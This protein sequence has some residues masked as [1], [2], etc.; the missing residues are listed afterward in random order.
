MK[1]AIGILIT[2]ALFAWMFSLCSPAGKNKTGHEYMPDMY[3]AVGYEANQYN[4]YYW[5]HWDKESTFSKAQLS[6]PRGTV[7]GSVPRGMTAVYYGGA[8]KLDIVRGKNAPNAIAATPNGHAP[9]YFQNTEDDRAR[10]E[11]DMVNNPF[12]ITKAGLDRAKPLYEI[13]C[14]ICHGNDGGGNGAL[15]ATEKYPAQPKNLVA[16]DMIAAGNGRYYFAIMYGK[17]VM[18]SYTDKLSYE[19]R[20][21]VIHYIRALQAKAKKLEYNEKANTLSNVEQP[22]GG[23]ASGPARSGNTVAAPAA[24][25]PAPTN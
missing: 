6:Q 8:E 1:Y 14:G 7:E 11:K 15:V 10:C 3:H 2:V 16:D 9:F 13:Y 25:A 21:Q 18:G 22:G 12:P 5:N 4:D 24:A 19:E 17:N 20:W 23:T